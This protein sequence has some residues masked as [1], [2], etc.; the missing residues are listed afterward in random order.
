MFGLIRAAG[1]EDFIRAILAV[2]AQA[3]GMITESEGPIADESLCYALSVGA[4][5]CSALAGLLSLQNTR[6]GRR[7][8]R[9]SFAMGVIVGFGVQDGG[10]LPI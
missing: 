9:L 1:F 10:P 6:L 5:E 7:G 4:L 2:R 3:L 8:W